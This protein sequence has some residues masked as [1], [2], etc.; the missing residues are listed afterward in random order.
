VNVLIQTIQP[1]AKTELVESMLTIAPPIRAVLQDSNYVPIKRAKKNVTT[2]S[3]RA[4]LP[5]KFTNVRTKHVL[6]HQLIAELE[7][8]VA[9]L[10]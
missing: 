6:C 5:I 4:V 3:F 10:Q 7:L 9:T 2:I 8:H 1:Y